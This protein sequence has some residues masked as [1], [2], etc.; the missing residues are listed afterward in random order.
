MHPCSTCITLRSQQCDV[1][2]GSLGYDTIES[3]TVITVFQRNFM[4]PYSGLPLKNW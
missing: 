4:P 1:D 3:V 2:C